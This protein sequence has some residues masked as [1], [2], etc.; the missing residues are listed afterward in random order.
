MPK[1]PSPPSPPEVK[2]GCLCGA[3]GVFVAILLAIYV[4]GILG[5]IVGIAVTVGMDQWNRRHQSP[6][7]IA[8][9]KQRHAEID[10][11]YDALCA[12][13]KAQYN[14]ER[15]RWERS[16][17][18]LRCGHV[19]EREGEARES[20]DI[21]DFC[22]FYERDRAAVPLLEEIWKGG[23]ARTIFDKD[24]RRKHPVATGVI[25]FIFFLLG[26]FCYKMAYHPSGSDGS[27]HA[28]A[29]LVTVITR[30]CRHI[31][32]RPAVRFTSRPHAMSRKRSWQRLRKRRVLA[33]L[34]PNSRICSRSG[35]IFPSQMELRWRFL[36]GPGNV[37]RCGC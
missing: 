13:L 16:W 18:C 5:W 19:F 31:C 25:I 3:V 28:L 11:R 30:R 17:C 21:F 36:I 6:E 4:S 1:Q 12:S 37:S 7:V 29:A 26:M 9:V 15:E 20:S 22:D 8:A 34:I 24:W 10:K 14:E 27:G 35:E 33:S 32:T 23:P 2:L